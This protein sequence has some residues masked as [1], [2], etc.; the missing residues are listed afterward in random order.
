MRIAL[1]LLLPWENSMIVNTVTVSSITFVGLST[2]L[3][4]RV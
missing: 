2:Y 1:P 4:S 3:L